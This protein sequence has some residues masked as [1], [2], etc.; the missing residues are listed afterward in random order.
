M[1]DLI[2]VRDIETA[3][4]STNKYIILNVYISDLVNERI[5]VIEIIVKVHLVHNL[6]VKLLIDVDVLD[7]EG[8]NLSFCKHS[9][10]INDKD[11]WE[12]NIHAHA[13]DNTRVCCKIQALKQLT[14]S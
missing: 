1:K 8:M 5:E 12:I 10:T 2:T 4:Y 6:K 7:F 3:R 14:I 13:R 9:L 11:R